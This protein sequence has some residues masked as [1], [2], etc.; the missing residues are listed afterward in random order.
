MGA[1]KTEVCSATA[2]GARG[3]AGARRDDMTDV[4]QPHSCRPERR[5]LVRA[6]ER[7]RPARSAHGGEA[8]EVAVVAPEDAPSGAHGRLQP[9]LRRRGPDSSCDPSPR[10]RAPLPATGRQGPWS[11]GGTRAGSWARASRSGGRCVRSSGGARG[12]PGRTRGCEVEDHEQGRGRRHPGAEAFHVRARSHMSRGTD[13]GKPRRSTKRPPGRAGQ[14]VASGSRVGDMKGSR[15]PRGARR[16]KG[17]RPAPGATRARA[18]RGPG[19]A[20]ASFVRPGARQTSNAGSREESPEERG[21]DHV[22][23]GKAQRWTREASRAT[24]RTECADRGRRAERARRRSRPRPV[25]VDRPRARVP[26]ASPREGRDRGMR[27]AARGNRRASR[28]H[29]HAHGEVGDEPRR[30]RGRGA[31]SGWTDQCVL[32]A[33]AWARRALP[34]RSSAVGSHWTAERPVATTDAPRPAFPDP[35]GLAARVGRAQ[36][37]GDH[38]DHPRKR[39]DQA[40]VARAREHL[41][42][43]ERSEQQDRGQGAPLQH[44][45]ERPQHPRDPRRPREW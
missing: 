25:V 31:D 9:L 15:S 20:A 37:V 19:P 17:Q 41:P 7:R 45:F 33:A 10:A 24:R 43:R 40:H 8:R 6:H 27:G 13:Q 18:W 2:I 38:A 35:E 32:V 39:R 29:G 21:R 5:V 44:A 28:A 23:G 4:R 26:P 3:A 36:Q 42:R 1:A 22:L 11:R 12:S 30:R 14:T 16:A 34:L